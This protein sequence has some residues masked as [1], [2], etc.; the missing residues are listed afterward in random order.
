[1]KIFSNISNRV[2]GDYKILNKSVKD[3]E[4]LFFFFTKSICKIKENKR[5]TFLSEMRLYWHQQLLPKTRLFISYQYILFR[6]W[7]IYKTESNSHAVDACFSC[8]RFE[9]NCEVARW[10]VS[11]IF[12]T[13]HCDH[14]A[15]SKV[16]V[17]QNS[18]SSGETEEAWL[19][20]P[21][22]REVCN[23]MERRRSHFLTLFSQ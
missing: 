18:N 23:F 17:T 19:L 2:S 20:D 16:Y 15:P 4:M 22:D 11:D 6:K 21:Y 13:G 8:N 10:W 5:V 14:S 9:I 7:W 3:Q 12:F 1:M